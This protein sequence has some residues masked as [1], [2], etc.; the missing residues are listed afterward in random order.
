MGH[1]CERFLQFEIYHS[2][3]DKDFNGRILRIF[4]FG[5]W[6]EDYI[7]RL[8]VAAG[9]GL[10]VKNNAGWQFGF[11]WLDGK[12]QGHIDGVFLNGPDTMAY[13]ALWEAKSVQSKDWRALVKEK[14]KKKYPVYY[15]QIQIYQK[16]MGLTDNPAIFSAINRDSLEIYWEVVPHDPEFTVLLE[17]KGMRIIAACEAG[18]MLP[19]AFNDPNYYQCKWCE[20]HSLCW[21][22]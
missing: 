9:Y 8:L 15:S 21:R 6:S 5:H 13:P 22:G 4:E 18:E 11:K 16:H 12:I 19:R 7:A 3:K 2:P 10:K 1:P 20:Y 14:V 17:A